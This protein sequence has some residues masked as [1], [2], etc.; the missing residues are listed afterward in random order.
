MAEGEGRK[1]GGGRG[2]RKLSKSM[3]EGFPREVVRAFAKLPRVF[4][5]PDIDK[6]LGDR[7][8]RSMKWK[9]LRKMESMGIIKHSTKKYYQKLYDRVSDWME[10]E[11]IPKL[12]KAEMEDS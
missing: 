12:R 6:Q 7:I 3:L 9:Y 10:K 11:F 2:K 4:K 5:K 8:S 1:A